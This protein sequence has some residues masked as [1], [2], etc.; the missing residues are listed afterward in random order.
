[1]SIYGHKCVPKTKSKKPDISQ[2]HFSISPFYLDKSN[3]IFQKLNHG[4]R[5]REIYFQNQLPE[6]D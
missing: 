2:G 4:T 3:N 6:T 1:M 5:A